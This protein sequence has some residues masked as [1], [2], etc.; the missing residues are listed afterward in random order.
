MKLFDSFL[1]GGF[2]CADHIN[3]SGER[4]DLHRETV[5]DRLAAHDYGLLTALGI[6][7]VR[8]GIVWS[9][10][11]T[12]PYVFDFSEVGRRIRAAEAAGV[13]ILWDLCHFGY[14]DGLIPTHPQFVDRFVA[15]CAAFTRFHRGITST[16]LFVC[17]INEISFLSWHSGEVRGTVPF[18]TGSG[19]DI[20]W[21]L[22][23]AAIAGIA[24]LKELA[25]D[26]RIMTIEPLIQVHAT[27]YSDPDHV[28]RLNNDQF[29]A[30][31]IIAG[32]MCPDLG[33]QESYLDILGFNC[34]YDGQW[35]DGST[36]LAWPVPV[37]E[38]TR[39]TPMADM[40]Q[41][42]SARY[43]R[44]FF[45]SETG[46]FGDNRPLWVEETTEAC[47]YVQRHNPDFQGVCL[48]PVV[49]RPDWD[50]LT[51]Y[52]NCGL[53]DLDEQQRRI[54]HSPTIAAVME[55]QRTL[56]PLATAAR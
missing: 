39:R 29:Q 22:C 27:E 4:I 2:E 23:R 33:G 8:E 16:T 3:R 42:A 44:P 19:W 53:W 43:G 17:P 35:T 31:D 24:T 32:R 48:Y 50:N 9:A 37:G 1:I 40:L 5:H 38:P 54:P 45:L 15:L 18:A 28:V 13:Q 36:H 46:H 7:T 30:A 11:E 55:M 6:R 26:C 25:P 21:H 34:Y 14:P 49:D 41:R 51:D 10:V 12:A 52:S 20:K 47:A 56:D